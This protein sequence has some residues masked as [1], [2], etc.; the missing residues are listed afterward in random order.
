MYEHAY[1]VQ[2]L[3][4]AT[5]Q[6]NIS[7]TQPVSPFLGS[8]N[9][10]QIATTDLAQIRRQSGRNQTAIDS[11]QWMCRCTSILPPSRPL[12]IPVQSLKN[13]PNPPDMSSVKN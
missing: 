2:F 11:C 6:P 3:A 10:L 5:R 8:T 12:A 4:A 13:G 7:V 1:A 9:M